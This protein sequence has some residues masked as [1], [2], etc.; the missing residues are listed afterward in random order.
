MQEEHELESTVLPLPVETLEELAN[1]EE[2]V[3]IVSMP[4][5]EEEAQIQAWIAE[6]EEDFADEPSFHLQLRPVRIILLEND[7]ERD[8]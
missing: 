5:D 3:V 8:S 6:D 2:E 4:T 1:M 7:R